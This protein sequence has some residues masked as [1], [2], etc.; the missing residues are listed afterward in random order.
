MNQRLVN[1]NMLPIIIIIIDRRISPKYL[2]A[3]HYILTVPWSG[4]IQ[5]L[6][7]F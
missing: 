2:M 1:T 4:C 7:V 6:K 3:V 5:P